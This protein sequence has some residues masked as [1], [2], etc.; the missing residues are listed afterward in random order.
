MSWIELGT[1]EE[2][3]SICYRITYDSAVSISSMFKE[4][5]NSSWKDDKVIYLS[6]IKF[7]HRID[8]IWYLKT[9]VELIEDIQLKTAIEEFINNEPFNYTH[10]LDY[11]N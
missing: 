6:S 9:N 11:L 2:A 1:W 10:I 8:A 4:K 3:A 5:D 7:E